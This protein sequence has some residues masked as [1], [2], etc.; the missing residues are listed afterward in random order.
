MTE[1]R[2]L[3]TYP[4]PTQSQGQAV[5]LHSLR[6]EITTPTSED[7][8]TVNKKRRPGA[9]IAR[10][11][12]LESSINTKII[13][14]GKDKEQAFCHVRGW[15]GPEDAPIMQAESIVIERYDDLLRQ[16]VFDAIDNGM[17]IPTGRRDHN[18][19]LETK[20]GIP[21]FEF[22]PDG[23]P[24]LKE[25][26]AQ[27]QLMKNHLGKIKFA[28]RSTMGKAERNVILKLLGKEDDGNTG[29]ESDKSTVSS[30][31]PKSAQNDEMAAYRNRIIALLL[32]IHEG[33]KALAKATF[34][35]VAKS[36]NIAANLPSELKSIEDAK[37]VY[38]DIMETMKP[39]E[40]EPEMEA[41]IEDPEINGPLTPEE[42]ARMA[43]D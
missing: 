24:V 38:D 36:L 9:R 35:T 23:F 4:Q 37:M 43:H 18:G 26:F 13:V 5:D 40:P 42:E 10:A 14:F 41:E 19:R 15:L 8:Y 11:L 32:K 30:N 3:S 27:F 39:E 7:M 12:A 33:D 1:E 17:F 31:A 25:R 21:D 16:A 2:R 6:R 28:E 29:E 20:K 34:L 22:G